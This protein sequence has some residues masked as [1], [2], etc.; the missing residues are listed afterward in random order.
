MRKHSFNQKFN[1]FTKNGQNFCGNFRTI[2][3]FGIMNK[4]KQCFVKMK[5]NVAYSCL[6]FG[7]DI[8]KIF[9]S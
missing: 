5:C 2:F 1:K 6:F 9:R 3:C 4:L 7:R 8:Y